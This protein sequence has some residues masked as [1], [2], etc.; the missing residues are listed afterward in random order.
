MLTTKLSN[1][2]TFKQKPDATHLEHQQVLEPSLQ[3]FTLT[4]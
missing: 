4:T 1:N 3:K 2:K